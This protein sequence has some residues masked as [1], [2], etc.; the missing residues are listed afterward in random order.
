M[1]ALLGLAVAGLLAASASAQPLIPFAKAVRA[2]E[3]LILSGE[4]GSSP[5][6]MDP[7]T[8]GMDAAAKSAMDKIGRTL[9]ANDADYGDVVKCT[10][11]L[12][13]MAAWDRFNLTYVKYFDP[14]RMPARSAFGVN[15][16]AR[17]AV[18]EVECLAHKPS[19]QAD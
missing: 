6:G 7:Q 14:A 8:D 1:R 15:G 18:V 3:F 10:V 13:D 4:I 2:G 9:A 11:M 5:P 12:A 16:L 17:G 19:K